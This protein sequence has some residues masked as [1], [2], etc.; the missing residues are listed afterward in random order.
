MGVDGPLEC[1]LPRHEILSWLSPAGPYLA[2]KADPAAGNTWGFTLKDDN[3]FN[4]CQEVRHTM[5]R[6]GI[7]IVAVESIPGPSEPM[8]AAYFG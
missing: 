4:G 5:R 3:E 8:A 6:K 1:I 7:R 2:R